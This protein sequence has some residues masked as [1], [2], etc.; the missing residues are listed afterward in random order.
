MWIGFKNFSVQISQPQTHP[1]AERRTDGIS[2][3]KIYSTD[4]VHSLHAL[5]PLIFRICIPESRQPDDVKNTP[6]DGD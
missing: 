6:A 2:Q 4:R 3:R 1:E 5:Q